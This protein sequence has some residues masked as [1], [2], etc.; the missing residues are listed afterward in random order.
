MKN[1]PVD[2]IRNIALAGHGGT[3]KTSLIEAMLNT[4]GVTS[5]LGKVDDGNTVSDYDVDEISRKMSLYTSVCPLEWK[6]TKINLVDTPGFADFIGDVI[7]AMSA[8]ETALIVVDGSGTVEV[9]T[10]NAWEKATEAGISKVFFINKRDKENMSWTHTVEALREAYGHEV[11]PVYVP[12]GKEADFTGVVD[13]LNQ[14]AY[15]YDSAKKAAEEI[16][17]PADM[18]D[19][20]EGLREQ[21]IENIAEVDDE[22]T[23]KYLEEMTLS[24]EDI[25]FGFRKGICEGKF[26]PVLVG[27]AATNVGV[28]T[29]LDFIATY[30]PAPKVEEGGL[31][32]RVFKTLADPYVGKLTYFKVISGTFAGDSR[33]YDV[34]TEKEERVGQVYQV[35]GKTQTGVAEITTGDI[36][37]VAKLAS[38][39]TGDTLGEKG[40]EKLEDLNFPEPVYALAVL[41]ANKAAEDKM[42]PAFAKLMEEDPTFK[43]YRNIETGQS[44]VASL[45]DVHLGIT[46]DKLKRKFG[47]EVTTEKPK[48]AYRETITKTAEAQGKHKKQTGGS[49]QYGDCTIRMEPLPR[50]EGYEFVDAIVGG[51][52]PRQYIPAVD[53][54][55]QEAMTKG[56][57]AGCQCVDIKIT[58]FDGSYHPVDSKD[59]AFQMAGKIA[60]KAAAE[61]AK[62]VILEPIMKVRIT[63]PSD[64]MGDVIGDLNTKR[65]RVAGMDD[66]GGGKQIINATVPQKEMLNYCIELRSLSKGRG[67]FT[68]E[69]DHY[70]EAP[71]NVTQE[72]IA[73]YEKSKEE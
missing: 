28:V 23:E 36:G 46:M 60:F 37:A 1:Y 64:C 29:L 26:Y 54:G 3:G 31:K 34:N 47:V 40:T 33:V 24:E 38:V 17:I 56:I 2:A 20:V 6:N 70:E 66:A 48:V 49:G 14:K 55:I 71:M 61:K 27:S 42:G 8:V 62:P 51:A 32:A 44:I 10:D 57:Q 22:L 41:A 12:I 72:I 19:Q 58:C 25:V 18:A 5:R 11:T 7:G 65:G 73:E 13:L 59:I 52:I 9:G 45:G 21:L 50:G 39:Q 15:K 35:L 4:A 68:S 16:D 53:K 69:F 63:V 30:C 67:K 43:T